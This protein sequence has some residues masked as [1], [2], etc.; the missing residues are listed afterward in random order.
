[1][2]R[3]AHHTPDSAIA[4]EFNK[5][6]L[7]T[8]KPDGTHII[9][10]GGWRSPDVRSKIELAIRKFGLTITQ[11]NGIWYI[12]HVD[13][14]NRDRY[15]FADGMSIKDGEVKGADLDTDYTRVSRKLID[16]YV[17]NWAKTWIKGD[18]P[19]PNP[20]DPYTFYGVVADKKEPNLAEMRQQTFEYL[21][22]EYYFGS[23][24]MVAIKDVGGHETTKI[25]LIGKFHIQDWLRNGTMP[26][27]K[28]LNGSSVA[29]QSLL[30]KFL[31]KLHGIK[32]IKKK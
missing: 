18:L 4:V 9:D 7:I 21:D 8:L 13:L 30:K 1:M 29:L 3:I 5:R 24:I 25:D 2:N 11:Q 15:I 22:S 16:K 6:K 27:S 26:P 19:P 10:T 17:S 20:S 28:L 14:T 23:M 31:Y 32:G 12:A